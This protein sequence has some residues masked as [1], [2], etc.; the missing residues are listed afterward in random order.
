MTLTKQISSAHHGS[1]L[2]NVSF[3]LCADRV[4]MTEPT[5]TVEVLEHPTP[6]HFNYRESLWNV[7][8][9]PQPVTGASSL[10]EVTLKG[11]PPVGN[12][13]PSVFC[14]FPNPRLI[15]DIFLR[16]Y[17]SDTV[18]RAPSM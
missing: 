14:Y 16:Y 9:Y 12:V 15:F 5:D 8:K 17:L 1:R 13:I 6:Y 18:Y 11:F 3:S 7:T 10:C 4:E 2:K